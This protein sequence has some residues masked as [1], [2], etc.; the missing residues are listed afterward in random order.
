[1]GIGAWTLGILRMPTVGE[2]KQRHEEEL[3]MR[4]QLYAEQQRAR[5]AHIMEEEEKRRR[6]EQSLGAR[7]KAAVKQ[8]AKRRALQALKARL[9][10]VVARAVAV[11]LGPEVLTAI[12]IALL[13]IIAILLVIFII[14]A[15]IAVLCNPQG[16]GQNLAAAG[17]K[18]S[19]IISSETCEAFSGLSG[20]GT[21][22][23]RGGALFCQNPQ[24]VA[25]QYQTPY[26]NPQNDPDLDKI[27]QCIQGRVS[28][29]GSI[30]TFEVAN[31]FC[32]FSRGASIYEETCGNCAHEENS[33]HYGGSVSAG[34]QG[35]LAV[36]FGGS[37]GAGNEGVIGPQILQAA[38]ACSQS[39]GIPLKRLTCENGQGDAVACADPGANHIHISLG[40][41]DRDFG[42]I[43]TR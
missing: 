8:E 13:V 23:Q 24:I 2:E 1:M 30:Y 43:N 12:G 38:L 35:S 29:V 36:D 9:A 28:N 20:V 33:C 6:E 25:Q 14:V 42:L 22:I 3:E 26:P 41:C 37:P 4:E 10:P 11:L 34:T 32:N 7:A 40:K 21:A 16:W 15:T 5:M 31:T 17:V 27:I 39:L 18:L 19:G